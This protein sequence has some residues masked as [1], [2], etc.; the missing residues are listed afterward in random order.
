[1]PY[2]F[3]LMLNTG[4]PVS[5][6]SLELRDRLD[7]F[8]ALDQI[9]PQFYRVR[10]VRMDGQLAPQ[11]IV[12]ASSGPR[13]PGFQGMLG[14]QFLESFRQIHFDRDTRLLNLIR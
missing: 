2:R 10:G 14:L 3:E 12:R 6:V 4:R 7:A 1:L 11:L 13:L 9:S 8:G 5:V